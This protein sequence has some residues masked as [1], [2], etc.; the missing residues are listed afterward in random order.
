MRSE[1]RSHIKYSNQR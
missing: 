1:N